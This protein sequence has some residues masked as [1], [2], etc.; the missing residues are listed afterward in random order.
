MK[1]HKTPL[2]VVFYEK[3]PHNSNDVRECIASGSILPTD[4]RFT[5]NTLINRVF[6]GFYPIH[7][8]AIAFAIHAGQRLVDTSRV[9]PIIYIDRERYF[10]KV[11]YIV[12]NLLI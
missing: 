9:T 11:K 8:N 1:F 10:K 2:W 12:R 7:K 4:G 3:D 5:I 6:R